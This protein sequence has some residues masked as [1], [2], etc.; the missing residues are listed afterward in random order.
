MLTDEF[1][2]KHPE[3]DHKLVK[4]EVHVASP[5]RTFYQ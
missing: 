3:L 2:P 5:T 4:T 1:I